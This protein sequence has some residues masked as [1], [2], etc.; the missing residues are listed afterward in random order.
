[1]A[2]N[3]LDLAKGYLGDS[4]ISQ[5]SQFLG[6]SESS[7]KNA[8]HGAVLPSMLGALI[9]KAGSNGGS[10]LLNMIKND[11]HDGGILDNLSGLLGGG[12]ALTGL[13]G[14]GGNIVSSLLGN[15]LGALL[16]L[17]S[18]FSGVKKESAGTLMNL[19]APILMGLLG[20][21]VSSNGLNAGGLLNLLSSQ[22]DIVKSALPSSFSSALGFG[23][24][25]NTAAKAVESGVDEGKSL[26][27]RLLPWLLLLAGVFGLLYFLKTCKKPETPV[28]DAPV[29][30]DTV[31]AQV[32]TMMKSKLVLPAGSAEEAMVNWINSADFNGDDK[33][34]WFDFPEIGFD[35]GKATIVNPDQ[36]VKLQNIL[37]VLKEYP[38]V[39][40]KIGGYTDSD[41]DDK[42]NQVLSAGRADAAMA[43][44]VSKGIAA[45]RM[46]A[47]G[48]G[49]SNPVAPNDNE[50]NKT[51]NRRISLRVISK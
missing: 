4:A 36:D 43:W 6:E 41:G 12:S 32:D 46:T 14:G 51:K 48:Y 5:V 21:Q 15:K 17:I 39:K 29:M 31:A 44:L 49:E 34:K 3:L 28:V 18:S 23:N 2:L 25:A 35:K 20:K 22:S 9:N 45:D 10:D 13:L 38:S 37:S 7:T 19:A 1:M 42:K 26:I 50:A 30:V 16:P 11:N 40:V 27:N 24:M 8:I 47:E 33:T